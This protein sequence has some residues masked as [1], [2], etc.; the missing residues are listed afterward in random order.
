MKTLSR[1]R[2]LAVAGL[3]V[4]SISSDSL[5]QEIVPWR[6]ISANNDCGVNCLVVACRLLGKATDKQEIRTLAKLGIRGTNFQNLALA[7]RQKG[8][9]CKGVEWSLRQLRAWEKPAIAHWE[10]HFVLVR[11]F[12]RPDRIRIIDPPQMPFTISAEEFKEKWDGKLLLLSDKPI[13]FFVGLGRTYVGVAGIVL[14]VAALLAVFRPR[15]LKTGRLNK[16]EAAKLV[17]PLSALVSIFLLAH[18]V[19]FLGTDCLAEAQK[20]TQEKVRTAENYLE[21]G[22][23]KVLNR[24]VDFGRVLEGEKLK[25]ALTLINGSERPIEIKGVAASCACAATILSKKI[26]PP[27]EAAQIGVT[28]DTQGLFGEVNKPS[29]IRFEN[30]DLKPIKLELKAYVYVPSARF[31]KSGLYFDRVVAGTEVLRKI[32]IANKDDPASKWEIVEVRTSSPIITAEYLSSWGEIQVKLNRNAPIGPIDEEVIVM[33]KGQDGSSPSEVPIKGEVIGPLKAI[34]EHFY[35]GE[36]E[37]NC[38]IRRSFCIVNLRK[39]RPVTVSSI[40]ADEANLNL[41]HKERDRTVYRVEFHAPNRA[42]F[43]KGNIQLA[44]DL[45]EQASLHI[46]YAGFVRD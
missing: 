5:A 20:K 4:M 22:D 9:F 45:K 27:R 46:P 6:E 36:V 3:V 35:L 37:K 33:I 1:M 43:F 28:L 26:I 13:S 30:P 17:S 15:V 23:N 38:L 12:E 29:L 10:N 31:A 18:G 11:E 41:E 21:V 19:G 34:P 39:D 32:D 7:A 24:D 16:V 2:Q 40:A 25:Y 44:T 42:G 8:L 14:C